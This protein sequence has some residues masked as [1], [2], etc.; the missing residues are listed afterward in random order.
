MPIARSGNDVG[1]I[2]SVSTVVAMRRE[3]RGAGPAR[4]VV[5]EPAVVAGC[6][7]AVVVAAGRVV[8]GAAGAVVVGPAVPA[9]SEASQAE[10]SVVTASVST[11]TE[12]AGRGIAGKG[13][14]AAREAGGTL[15]RIRNLLVTLC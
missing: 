10:A 14:R 2:F 5:V 6:P 11:A 13:R 15:R 12:R 9:A 7:A 3:L 4:V 1:R 8:V